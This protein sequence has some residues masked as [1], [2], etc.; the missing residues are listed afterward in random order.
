MPWGPKHDPRSQC[1]V[2]PLVGAYLRGSLRSV[3][4]PGRY[5]HDESLDI[6]QSL[7]G[8]EAKEKKKK[9]TASRPEPTLRAAPEPCGCIAWFG[10]ADFKCA[11]CQFE[12]PRH[13]IMAWPQSPIAVG[14]PED[15]VVGVSAFDTDGDVSVHREQ[16]R[17]SR[18]ACLQKANAFGRPRIMRLQPFSSSR[19]RNLGA[20]KCNGC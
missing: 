8:W 2:S 14:I 20:Q 19:S 18:A 7:L 15:I 6:L 3:T 1:S 17:D 13:G 9:T 12:P 16:G 5:E 10:T 4:D 11:I